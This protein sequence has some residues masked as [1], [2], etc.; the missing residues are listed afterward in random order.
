MNWRVNELVEREE[1]TFGGVYK[2][3]L[4]WFVVVSNI[5]FGGV[6][7]TQLK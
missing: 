2:T 1:L 6:Y 4:K 7:K 3:Q 5:I